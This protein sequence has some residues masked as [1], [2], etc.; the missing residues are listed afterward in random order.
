MAIRR[1]N[2]P[3]VNPPQTKYTIIAKMNMQPNPAGTQYEL[4]LY[5]K[6]TVLPMIYNPPNHIRMSRNQAL[7][8]FIAAPYLFKL[9]I[10][11]GT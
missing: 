8:V 11:G 6:T 4:R 10:R 2:H 9:I 7:F 1:I 3:P 5:R